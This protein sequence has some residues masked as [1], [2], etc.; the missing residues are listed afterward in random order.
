[1]KNKLSIALATGLLMSTVAFASNIFAGLSSFTASGFAQYCADNPSIC[2]KQDFSGTEGTISCPNENHVIQTIYVHAGDG[3]NVYELP[4][5]GFSF[6]FTDGGA[7]ATVTV[8]THPHNLSWLG[9]VCG[10]EVNSPTPTPTES[11]EPTPTPSDD[12]ESTPTPTPTA[13]PV[14]TSTPRV[15]PS[16]APKDAGEVD[17]PKT[18]TSTGTG[19]QVLGASTFAATGSFT[20]NLGML[21]MILGTLSA[22]VSAKAYKKA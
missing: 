22:Y 8:T 17:Y 13:T 1:M 7:T 19:G 18:E 4:D 14:S 6:V 9:V 21:L 5:G 15:T 12:P 3:Q 11:S 10:R 2:N 20:Q 16:P